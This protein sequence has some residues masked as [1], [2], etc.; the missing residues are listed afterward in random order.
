MCCTAWDKR[1]ITAHKCLCN[2]IGLV[3]ALGHA[4]VWQVTESTDFLFVFVDLHYSTSFS[5]WTA[6]QVTT[7]TKCCWENLHMSDTACP[8]RQLMHILCF[9]WNHNKA[10]LKFSAC[11][12]DISRLEMTIIWLDCQHSKYCGHTHLVRKGKYERSFSGGAICENPGDFTHTKSL[13]REFHGKAIYTP[14]RNDSQEPNA[15]APVVCSRLSFISGMQ[16][17]Y[18]ELIL[19]CCSNLVKSMM[20]W[21][22]ICYHF[23]PPLDVTI[24]QATRCSKHLQHFL[25]VSRRGCLILNIFCFVVTPGDFFFVVQVQ[26]GTLK[27]E[28]CFVCSVL[29]W[30]NCAIGRK[31]PFPCLASSCCS[32][33]VWCCS[34]V[35]FL[36]GR[37]YLSVNY[38]L[39][40]S[41]ACCPSLTYF[42]V[43]THLVSCVPK[44]L[45]TDC[46]SVISKIV[47]GRGQLT[48][49]LLE[50]LCV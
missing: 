14:L 45:C 1:V 33:G 48:N 31:F 23:W 42:C 15:P 7:A 34:L 47:L 2:E 13:E 37:I 28:R 29:L 21:D 5:N 8:D 4:L 30:R 25:A 24:H 10:R 27:C 32:T 40:L 19:R 46:R 41:L 12:S 3:F 11:P 17:A 35:I 39:L 44:T 16:I 50:I 20:W 38:E 9:F 49:H 18:R 43:N 22:C 36:P 26:L 6:P